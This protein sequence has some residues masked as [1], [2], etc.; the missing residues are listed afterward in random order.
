MECWAL[1][2]N[3]F[4]RAAGCEFTKSIAKVSWNAFGNGLFSLSYEMIALAFVWPLGSWVSCPEGTSIR[5]SEKPCHWQD[6]HFSGG[7][8]DSFGLDVGR[9]PQRATKTRELVKDGR[10]VYLFVSLGRTSSVVLVAL[11]ASPRSHLSSDHAWFFV[12]PSVGPGEAGRH[13]YHTSPP[14]KLSHACTRWDLSPELEEELFLGQQF[15]FKL[16]K[17]ILE[18]KC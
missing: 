3:A 6:G 7:G 11:P 17:R 4:F 13:F 12:V 2:Q 1:T 15:E 18:F 8:Q 10:W 5:C 16:K 9:M 14:W